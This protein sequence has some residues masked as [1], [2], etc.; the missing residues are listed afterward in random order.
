[1]SPSLRRESEESSLSDSIRHALNE[2]VID[3]RPPKWGF[4]GFCSKDTLT[5]VLFRVWSKSRIITRINREHDGFIILV[6]LLELQPALPR[7][8]PRALLFFFPLLPLQFLL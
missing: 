7:F 3:L 2:E 4:S 5:E 1:M 8:K 6:L